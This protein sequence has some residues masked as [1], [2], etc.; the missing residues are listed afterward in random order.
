MHDGV[1]VR[2]VLPLHGLKV[3]ISSRVSVVSEGG[4]HVGSSDGSFASAT[5]FF[6]HK[7]EQ[8]PGNN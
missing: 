4:L 8:I 2:C 7:G 3:L 1:L 6:M 5:V